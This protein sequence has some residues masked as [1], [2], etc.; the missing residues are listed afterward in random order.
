MYNNLLKIGSESNLAIR[1]EF[2]D[3]VEMLSY[4][5]RYNNLMLLLSLNVFVKGRYHQIFFWVIL[6][7]Y[8]CYEQH[9]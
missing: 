3:I 1:I 7:Q 4:E 8:I 5:K 2:Y 6:T 9:A